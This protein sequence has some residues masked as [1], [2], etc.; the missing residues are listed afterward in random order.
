MATPRIAAAAATL[1]ESF[2]FL[3]AQQVVSILFET[4]KDL[5]AP[6]ADAVYG[7]GVLDLE[8]AMSAT[9]AASIPPGNAGSG[10]GG[11]LAFAA[12]TIGGAV[13]YLMRDKQEELQKTVLVD[14]YGRAFQFDL[15]GRMSVRDAG[16]S[17][18]ALQ[19]RQQA[20]FDHVLL[21][22]SENSLTRVSYGQRETGL[23]RHT[24]A[25]RQFER[26]VSLL[27]RTETPDAVYLLGL[28]ADLSA[29]FGALSR[30]SADRAPVRFVSTKL[31]STPALGYSS[32]GSSFMHGWSGPRL[33]HRFGVSVIDDQEQNGLASNSILYE[34]SLSQE[35]YR[36][37][38]QLGALV[39]DGS[40]FGGSSG[41]PFSVDSASTYFL[42][43]NGTL[44]LTP[45]VRV[46]GG[47]FRGFSAVADSRD[48][49]LSDFSSLRSEGYALGL[50]A[51]RVFS[52]RGSFGVSYSRPLQSSSGSAVLTVPV[53][54]DRSTGAVSFDASG[55]DFDSAS[56]ERV[57]ETYYNYKL[58]PRSSLFIH[59][60]HTANPRSN[61]AA[62]RERTVF[63]GWRRTL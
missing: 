19:Q 9:G 4:A 29:N 32:I 13:A 34:S 61:L 58:R 8:A 22:R 36:L 28:N 6:G 21:N 42:G 60:S 50:V 45:R 17:I 15:P 57:I 10:G 11:G 51:D 40:L 38:W 31:F 49:L 27:H 41:G 48:S 54:Q 30:G 35:Q 5:G 12:L 53:S 39:E 20:T 14:S 16:L 44:D 7:H 1:L 3:T 52:D 25:D 26:F 24:S 18:F 56:R 59:F 63:V 2:G 55:V 47:Y 46:L 62:D 23:Y 43:I 33:E 37:G